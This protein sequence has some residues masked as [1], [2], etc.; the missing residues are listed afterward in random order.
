MP[1]NVLATREAKPGKIASWGHLA[2]YLLITAGIA[3]W[4]F[5]IQRAGLGNAPAGQIVD[6]SQ[7]MK[8]YFLDILADCALLYYCWVGVH[9]HGGNLETLSGG[10]WTSWKALA[11]DIAIAIPFWVVWEATAYGVHWLLGPGDSAR[12]V[13]AML[14]QSV[15]E[16]LVWILVSVTAG[17]CEEL[18]SRGYL[19]RQFHALSGSM[20]AAVLGQGVLF[21]L[22]HS[23]QGWK[24]VIVISALGVLYGALA[25]W[26]RNLRANI[27]AHAWSDIWEGWL[28]M[29]VWS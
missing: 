21:G 1:E 23:Y 2:G 17:F 22:M 4:G 24:Q 8:N 29:V 27:I 25:A 12:S 5:H 7:V 28:K 9:K 20:V 19:Q 15:P 14:P 3:A 10:L 26:R 13:A 11:Q 18:Q 16:I 6:H